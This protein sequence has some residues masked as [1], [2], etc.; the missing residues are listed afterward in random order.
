MADASLDL[1]D[2]LDRAGTPIK[3]PTVEESSARFWAAYEWL[4]EN[5]D[6]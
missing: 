3:L 2:Y 1:L 4:K 5:P 6:D